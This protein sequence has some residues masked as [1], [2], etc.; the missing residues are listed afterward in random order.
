MAGPENVVARRRHILREGRIDVQYFNDSVSWLPS[1]EA[2]AGFEPCLH[3]AAVGTRMDLAR[4][5]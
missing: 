2:R 5:V 3:F 4:A 1:P